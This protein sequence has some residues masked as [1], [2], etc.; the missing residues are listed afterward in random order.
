MRKGNVK[1][2]PT[3]PT[4]QEKSTDMIL[5]RLIPGEDVRKRK[6]KGLLLGKNSPFNSIPI[7]GQIL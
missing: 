1:Q 2:T 7:L 3:L 5:N 6:G 4:V